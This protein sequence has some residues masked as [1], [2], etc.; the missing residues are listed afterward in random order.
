M[1]SIKTIKN[2]LCHPEKLLFYFLWINQSY[3]QTGE[4]LILWHIIWDKKGTYIDIWANEPVRLNNTYF[5]YKKWWK[6]VNCEPNKKLLNK[7]KKVRPND[8]NLNIAVWNWSDSIAFYE[9]EPHTL[10]TCDKETADKYIKMWHENVAT[11]QVKVMTLQQIFEKYFH[12]KQVDILSV[13]VE[14][15]DLEILKSN[16]F[17]KYHPTYIILETLEYRNDWTWKKENDVYDPF[18]KNIWYEKIA[19]TYINTI[20]KY[21]K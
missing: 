20:Y 2:V 3:S 16:N 8:I 9:F 6:G 7:F 1:L 19:E 12:N 17:I 15:Y 14:W 21:V 18:M 5:F 11:Y 10:S 13:D 4:D